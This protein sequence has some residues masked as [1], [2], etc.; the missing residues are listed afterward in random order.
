[1]RRLSQ[2][3]DQADPQDSQHGTC[4]APLCC[5]GR[6][7]PVTKNTRTIHRSVII[8]GLIYNTQHSRWFSGWRARCKEHIADDLS[9]NTSASG[10]DLTALVIYAETLIE[11]AKEFKKHFLFLLVLQLMVRHELDLFPEAKQLCYAVRAV[12]EN[13]VGTIGRLEA[14]QK[15]ID[16]TRQLV[17]MGLSNQASFSWADITA[18]IANNGVGPV[19]NAHST[20]GGHP[21]DAQETR[22]STVLGPSIG[23]R[24]LFGDAGMGREKH[25]VYSATCI[26]GVGDALVGTG[27]QDEK[28]KAIPVPDVCLN[29]NFD[30]NHALLNPSSSVSSAAPIKKWSRWRYA[31]HSRKLRC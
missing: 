17:Q 23:P 19:T 1:M 10:N 18:H 11:A 25:A 2:G 12:V 5:N 20:S 7:H 15:H 13:L 22:G 16:E 28:V 31:A 14:I 29:H 27:P 30:P 24:R 9:P 3:H 6:G 8:N 26:A 4:P 21:T